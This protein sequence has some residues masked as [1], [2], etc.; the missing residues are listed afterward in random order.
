MNAHIDIP[1]DKIAAFCKRWK[2]TELA[3]FGSVLRDDFGPE[4]DVD[5][6]ARFE[7]KARHTLFDLD[8]MEEE[9]ATIF[10]RKVDLVSWQ[11]V[12]QSENYIRRKSILQS[13][14]TIYV[15]SVS[16]NAALSKSSTTGASRV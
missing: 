10:G 3:L 7:E 6:L 16:T 5:V 2:V 8:R 12:E 11:G 13:A 14:K 15:R 4:S 9:L 1:R